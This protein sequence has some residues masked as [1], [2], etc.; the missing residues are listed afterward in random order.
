MKVIGITGG[1]ASG[2]TTVA[3]MFADHG[4]VH[5]DAD[6]T[7]HRLMQEDA[8]MIAAIAG[9]FPASLVN[10]QINRRVLSGIV[11][12]D[13]AAL[14][15][16]EALIHPRVRAEEKKLIEQV[17]KANGKGVIL[18]IPLLFE[19]GAE[20]H[21][22]VTIAVHAPLEVAKK[23]A[24]SRAG[25]TEEKWQRLTARQLDE[26]ER[27][28]RADHVIPTEGSEEET[29]RHVTALLQKWGL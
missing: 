7:V 26:Q 10:G 17:C 1:I 5:F 20:K 27:C 6:F 24:F 23:R 16:L 3:Q 4:F 14:P 15:V 12:K 13:K 19:T 21:C 11:S 8:E 29:R 18:D 2:K 9:V 25:M 28:A 22:D